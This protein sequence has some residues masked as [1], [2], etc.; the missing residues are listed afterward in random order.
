MGIF[1]DLAS[2]T[3]TLRSNVVKSLV[4]KSQKRCTLRSNVTKSPIAKSKKS[5]LHHSLLET[6]YARPSSVVITVVP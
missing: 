6:K 4:A 3:C 2:K 5:R 1:F